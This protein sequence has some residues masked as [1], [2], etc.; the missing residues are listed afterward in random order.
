MVLEVRWVVASQHDLVAAQILPW[1]PL[2]P[3]GSVSSLVESS[4]SYRDHHGQCIQTVL[5]A[6]VMAPDESEWF[7]LSHDLSLVLVVLTPLA[8]ATVPAPVPQASPAW[9]VVRR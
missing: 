2:Y 5:Q 1:S 4:F 6:V 8:T 3:P 7:E 9:F